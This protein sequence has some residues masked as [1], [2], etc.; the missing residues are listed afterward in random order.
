MM[1]VF[2]ANVLYLWIVFL[3]GNQSIDFDVSYPQIEDTTRNSAKMA[4]E[5]YTVQSRHDKLRPIFDLMKR[6]H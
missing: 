5:S 1:A 2:F 4:E 3:K 6:S